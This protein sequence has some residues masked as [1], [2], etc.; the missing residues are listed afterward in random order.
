MTRDVPIEWAPNEKVVGRLAGEPSNA[1]IG[2]LLAHGAGAGQG[3]PIMGAVRDG[4]AAE[5]LPTMT[6]DYAYIAAGRKAPDRTAK[7]LA[8]HRA[9]ADALADMTAAV[10]LAGKSMGGRVGSHLVGDEGWPAAGVVFLGYPL[11]PMGK[12]EPR[13]TAHLTRI[14]V[15]Q[16]FVAGSRDRLG[17]LPLIEPLVAALADAELMVVDDGDHSLRVTKAAARTDAEVL[18]GVVAAIAAWI[19]RR[20]G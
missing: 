3:H 2:V 15:P 11:V 6:F 18:A 8:V 10:V 12:R 17:P 1:S 14:E 13:D 4:L 7:L 5:G 20:I 19:R 9:A 16:L